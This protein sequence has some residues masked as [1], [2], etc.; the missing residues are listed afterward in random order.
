MGD[1][2][3]HS[4]A[5]VAPTPKKWGRSELRGVEPIL[6]SAAAGIALG[7]QF[8]FGWFL[9]GCTMVL[10]VMGVMPFCWLAR[11]L[12]ALVHAWR[13]A[14]VDPMPYAGVTN[15]L[16]RLFGGLLFLPLGIVLFEAV[17]P[18]WL[19]LR[20][21]AKLLAWALP[22]LP[23]DLQ[24][25]GILVAAFLVGSLLP[26]MLAPVIWALS[27]EDPGG[28]FSFK[29]HRTSKAPQPAH[30][31]S[32][33]RSSQPVVYRSTPVEGRTAASKAPLTRVAPR[34][35]RV[36]ARPQR[37]DPPGASNIKVVD[38]D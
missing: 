9:T 33:S 1:S 10:T 31:T 18:A 28:F 13:D 23:A 8:G 26:A 3:E 22:E 4:A 16:Y 32:S 20:S 35:L 5:D 15:P 6:I 38:R 21:G 17:R 34:P 19:S 7:H 30:S 25:G 2:P 27:S 12:D 11:A 37:A 14:S 24:L 36:E 29:L